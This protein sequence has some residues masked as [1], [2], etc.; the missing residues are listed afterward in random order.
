[1]LP[2]GLG[3]E[4]RLDGADDAEALAAAHELASRKTVHTLRSAPTP[5]LTVLLVS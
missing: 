3:R 1:M 4:L 5:L 2:K